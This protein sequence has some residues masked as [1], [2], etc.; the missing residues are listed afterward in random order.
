MR[1]MNTSTCWPIPKRRRRLGI[2]QQVEVFIVLI[3]AAKSLADV[4]VGI[5]ELDLA[6]PFY[7]LV[8]Q[9]I[10]DP[11]PQRRALAQALGRGPSVSRAWYPVFLARLTNR[12]LFRVVKK[13]HPAR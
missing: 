9:L 12:L 3:F 7:H 11:Q 6:N 8:A 13:V 5:E 1:T 2:G 4:L 10:F